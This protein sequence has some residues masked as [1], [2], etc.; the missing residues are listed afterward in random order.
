L[1]DL[2]IFV[3]ES[4]DLGWTLDAPYRAGGSSRFL[5]IGALCIPLSKEYLARRVI[6]HL[7]DK[8]GWNTANEKK[9]ADLSESARTE[10]ATR[11]K[12]LR[13][14]N[15]DIFYHTITVQ[16]QNVMQHIR[17]DSNKLYNYMIRLFLLER[18]SKHQSIELVPDP[19]SI[20]VESGNSLPD[21]LQTE[22]W[23]TAK[24]KTMLKMRRRHSHE[25]QE[26][27]FADM[28]S[29]LVQSFHEDHEQPNLMIL[30][31]KIRQTRLF[32]R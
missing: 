24:C 14:A 2:S 27:Q 32:F 8:F 3:D 21:Y 19:R 16:K 28:L 18:M 1:A 25:C 26:L 9:W 10:F 11:A 29:G 17:D 15:A 23:F 20:K 12:Q 5:T 4:G 31:P 13:D 6:R 7:Y 30:G 22:L